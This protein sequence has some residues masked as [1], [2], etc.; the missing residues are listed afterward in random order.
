MRQWNK[1]W[2]RRGGF[3]VRDNIMMYQKMAKVRGPGWVRQ[4]S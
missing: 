3:R 4:I 1:D 2:N